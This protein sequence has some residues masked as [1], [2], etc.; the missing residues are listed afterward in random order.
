MT[1]A[2]P[3]LNVCVSPSEQDI[4]AFAAGQAGTSP[5]DYVRHKAIEAAEI[6]V[7]EY[8]LVT[9][10]AADWEKFAAWVNSP[11]KYVPALAQTYDRRSRTAELPSPRPLAAADARYGFDCGRDSLNQWFRRHAW[12][13][14]EARVSGTHVI[15]DTAT[16]EVIGYVALTASQIERAR[17]PEPEP[18]DR[19]DPVPALVLGQLAVDRRY[20]RKGYGRSLALF[21]MTAAVRFA[22]DIGCFC[23]FTHPL[24]DGVRAF[25]SYLGFETLPYDPRRSMAVRIGDLRQSGF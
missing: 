24:D 18:F 20:Q 9:I 11:V 19:P 16:G 15:C 3:M 6:D 12:E 1:D 7:L 21:A 25:L 13:N 2:S 8:R 4:L 5:A 14:Q 23:M 22:E 10:P 17:L